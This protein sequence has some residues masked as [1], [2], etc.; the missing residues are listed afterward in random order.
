MLSCRKPLAAL[1]AM[2]AAFAV[3]VPTASADAT[4]APAAPSVDPTVCE[5]LTI[6]ESPFGPTMFIGG[7]SLL[8]TLTN[9]GNSVGCAAPAPRPSLQGLLSGGWAQL[10]GGS[11]LL[12]AP[13][14]SR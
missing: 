10:P 3:A 12:P 11:G 13:F 8:S 6:S 9:A 4:A 2:A 1:A 14:G 7:A 5:L